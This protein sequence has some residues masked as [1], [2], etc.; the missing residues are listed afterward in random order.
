MC[1][2]AS[3][4]GDFAPHRSNSPDLVNTCRLFDEVNNVAV[5]RSQQT[6]RLEGGLLLTYL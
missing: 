2:N 5:K 1:G 3:I 4:I 6:L